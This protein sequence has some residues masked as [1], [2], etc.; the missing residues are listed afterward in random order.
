MVIYIDLV[1]FLNLAYDFLLLITVDMTL[2]RNS[3]LIKI[4][5]AALLGA[6]S[7]VILFLPFNEYILFSL[8][9]LISI[10]MVL[11]AYGYKDLKY[12]FNNLFYLYMCSVILGGFLYFLNVAFSY[13]RYGLVFVNEGLSVNYVALIILAPLILGLYVYQNKRIKRLYNYIYEVKI[14]FKDNEEIKCQGFLDSGNKLKDPITNKYIILIEKDLINYHNK[15]PLYVPFRTVNKKGLLECLPIKYIEVNKH[16]YNNYLIG[17]S[18]NK[19]NIE[20]INCLLNNKL[21]EEICFEN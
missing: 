16:K 7:L 3:K 6:I 13:K 17:I 15:V 9:I 2:K 18:T 8:K 20:G 19:F 10:F 5:L 11:I 1:F 12:T 14:V 21:L 4:F